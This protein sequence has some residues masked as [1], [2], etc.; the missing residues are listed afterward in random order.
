[1]KSVP[2]QALIDWFPDRKGLASGL[3]IAGF[4]SGL[5]GL[6][7]QSSYTVLSTR[8]L[9]LHSDDEHAYLQV[10]GVANLPG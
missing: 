3:V 7:L 10:L 4:G 9:I 1:M 8:S 5:S 2:N 6:S